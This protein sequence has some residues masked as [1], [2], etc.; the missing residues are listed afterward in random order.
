VGK[1]VWKD[2]N[3]TYENSYVDNPSDVSERIRVLQDALVPHLIKLLRN[4]FIDGFILPNGTKINKTITECILSM[5]NGEIK[6]CPKINLYHISVS[7][8]DRQRV[9]PACELFSR[10]MAKVICHLLLEEKEASNFFE[11]VN[12]L[13]DIF[14]S[15]VP[16][17]EMFPT[18]SAFG[19]NNP[20]Q[21]NITRAFYTCE[22]MIVGKK[23]AL[24]PFQKGF[25][26][27]IRSLLGCNSDLQKLYG[28]KY[29][30]TSRLN[31]DCL[32]NLSSQTRALGRAYDHPLTV[33][34]KNRLR[35]LIMS[36][37]ISDISFNSSAV[38]LE[39]DSIDF[40]TSSVFSGLTPDIRSFN[41][42]RK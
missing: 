17:N 31:Q 27:T 12:D 32:E 38:E 37:N 14:N 21:E 25:L 26:M 28:M 36:K 39:V 35:L 23:T 2:L 8:R 22:K 9:R 3:V 24:L 16:C 7:G 41:N 40:I 1:T 10:H 13:F 29:I 4:H 20:A 42:D 6:L 18:A 30:L 15:R 19:M 11:L 34:F 33:E 5:D